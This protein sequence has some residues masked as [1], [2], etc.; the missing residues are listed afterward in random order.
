M[1][2]LPASTRGAID[3]LTLA[4]LAVIA[5]LSIKAP[6]G[7]PGK[8]HWW[9]VWKKN[10]IEQVDKAKAE[11][12]A[13]QAA[14]AA[15]EKEA[16]AKKDAE[17][18]KQLKIGQ[19]AA[20]GTGVAIAAAQ[21]ATAAGQ[22]PVRELA[23]AAQL[24]KTNVAAME[25]AVGPADPARVR[26][27]ELMVANLNAGVAA[28]AKALEL[29]QGALDRTVADK[30][31]AAVEL[32]RVRRDGA[33]AV[34]AVQAKLDE[35]TAKLATFAGERDALARRYERLTFWGKLGALAT[36]ALLAYAGFLYLR[37]R[38]ARNLST[39]LVALTERMKAYVPP[40]AIGRLED[41]IQRDWLTVHD[42]TAK[43]VGKIKAHLRL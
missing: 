18:Q 30:A 8:N 34:A 23:T 25:Q 37:V 3:P 27:L 21:S 14:A 1:K 11:L 17:T 42:G 2:T 7:G 9:E 38:G 33:A 15:A 20:L 10:P 19:D 13:A 26:E 4:A 31:A 24:N 40:D 35:N 22:L 29:M 12:A 39:D 5:V 43:A 32:E 16:Q 36:A 6:S 28:G 41:E